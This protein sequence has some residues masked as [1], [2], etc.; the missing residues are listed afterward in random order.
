MEHR[1]RVLRNEN[2][3]TSHTIA[4]RTF[5]A[6][7]AAAGASQLLAQQKGWLMFVGTYTKTGSKGIYTWRLEPSGKITSIGLAAET[8]NPSFLAIHPSTRYLYAANEDDAG[9]ISAFEIENPAGQLKLINK[10][11][12]KGG[13]PCHLSFDH[14]GRV[15]YAAN[16]KDGVVSSFLIGKDGSISEAAAVVQHH[17]SSHVDKERQEGPHAHMAAVSPDN[18]LLLV[19]DLGLDKVM[20]YK[21]DAVKGTLEPNGAPFLQLPPG[22]GPRH[23]AFSKDARFVYVLGE[24]NATVNVFQWDSKTGAGQPA[25]T[26]SMLPADFKGQKS[27]AEIA[28]HPNGKFL[29]ASEPR[30]RQRCPL[31]DRPI[32]RD[33]HRGP[34]HAQ[35]W[36]NAAQLRHRPHRRLPLRRQSGRQQHRQLSHRSIERP[37][38]AARRHDR[39][40]G[41]GLHRVPGRSLKPRPWRPGSRTS[42]RSATN[43]RRPLPLCCPSSPS[44]TSS[45]SAASKPGRRPSTCS[46]S[47]PRSPSSSFA[48][49]R[50]WWAARSSTAWSTDGSASRACPSP[51]SSS[52]KSRSLPASSKSSNNP[53]ATSRPIAAFR[54][55]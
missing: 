30:P 35:P 10:V 51:P 22:T 16:Y 26:I 46:S 32:E 27:G 52:M 9:M 21:I 20:M 39:G 38:V 43:G 47:R 53:S 4:R 54:F 11:S 14:T 48:C 24:L 29:Y 8:S 12:S 13:W 7:T 34:A 23:L 6:A 55:C 15:C 2:T 31:P 19:P 42:T 50:S 17:G 25:Q 45:P 37:T 33:A 3:M 36:Q 40:D 5:L 18:H 49:P 41:A 28:V 1:L 44:S